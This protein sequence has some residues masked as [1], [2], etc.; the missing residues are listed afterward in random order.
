MNKDLSANGLDQLIKAM[1]FAAKKHRDQRR[2]DVDAT[3]YINHPIEL[4]SLLVHEGGITDLT[5]II[6]AILHDT[7][8]DTT[9][10][11]E[12]LEKFFGKEIKDIVMEVT[13]DKSLP[14]Q[15]RKRLQVKHAGHASH[16]ARLVKLAD[17]ICNL[18]D[19]VE[20]PP[21]EWPLERKREYYDW[22]K[23]VIDQVRG[24]HEGLEQ[25]FDAEYQK[26]P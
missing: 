16:T 20:H 23:E 13:D 1:D 21:A 26:K 4:A 24:T 12:E 11:A 18:R 7:V 15:V 8:E 6:A 3:P 19:M 14:K 5:T 22:A 9:T 10:T 17:K 2:K 25:L